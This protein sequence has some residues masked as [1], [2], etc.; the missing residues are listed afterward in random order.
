MPS[1][2]GTRSTR[3]EGPRLKDQQHFCLG[4]GMGMSCTS[5][6]ELEGHV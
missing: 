5:P 6:A 1:R 4:L 3:W 2:D